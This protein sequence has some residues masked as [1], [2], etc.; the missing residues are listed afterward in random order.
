MK[1]YPAKFKSF[2]QKIVQMGASQSLQNSTQILITLWLV[3]PIHTNSLSWAINHLRVLVKKRPSSPLKA[4]CIW[5]YYKNIYMKAKKPI[6]MSK[7]SQAEIPR[8]WEAFVELE[9][10]V[11]WL[12]QSQES[13]KHFSRQITVPRKARLEAKCERPTVNF[14][15]RV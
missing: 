8:V 15:F 11:Y 10:I 12:C 7:Q 4:T 2:L 5:Q 3:Y 14:I 1:S 13:L 9:F 6:R